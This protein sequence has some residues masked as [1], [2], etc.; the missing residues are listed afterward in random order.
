MFMK[1]KEIVFYFIFSIFLLNA[2]KV[3][4]KYNIP[5]GE[6]IGYVVLFDSELEPLSDNSGVKV[7]LETNKPLIE[8]T[9]DESGQFLFDDISSETYN[10][11]FEKE[12]YCLHKIISYQFV[13]GNKPSTVG[14][15]A[16]YT[17]PNFQIDSIK[18]SDLEIPNKVCLLITAKILNQ[19]ENTHSCCRLYLS[20]EQDVS[21]NNY[22]WTDDCYIN[23]DNT[24]SQTIYIDTMQFAIG[25]E[26]NLI[27]YPATETYQYYID[28]NTGNR[29]Y[30]SINNN[31]PSEVISFI[32]P[33]AASSLWLK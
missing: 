12:G 18:I 9:T 3:E 26:L 1:N 13:G 14:Q 32:V 28:I 8:I 30:T 24:L 17:L 22:V 29:I 23:T 21:F 11:V 7:T 4:T 2:C 25:S 31:K 33:E 27:I 10:I 19:Y 5:S 16:L 20:N 6:L 15:I